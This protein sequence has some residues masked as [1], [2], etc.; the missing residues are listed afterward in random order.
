MSFLLRLKRRVIYLK[1]DS[2]GFWCSVFFI[3][4]FGG[5][6]DREMNE[7]VGVMINERTFM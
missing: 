3:V 4:F 2:V 7:I 1:G 6:I 5:M